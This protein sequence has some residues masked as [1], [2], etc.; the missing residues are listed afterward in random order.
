MGTLTVKSPQSLHFHNTSPVKE[1][2]IEIL[3][4][5][6]VFMQ[7]TYDDDTKL[8]LRTADGAVH[9]SSSDLLYINSTQ[10]KT[11]LTVAKKANQTAEPKKAKEKRKKRDIGNQ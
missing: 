3:P 11:D 9:V 2:K 4:D 7:I 1:R 8:Q 10:E 5:G 6:E